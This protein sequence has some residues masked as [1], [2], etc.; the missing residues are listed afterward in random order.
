MYRNAADRPASP[1]GDGYTLGTA[2]ERLNALERRKVAAHDDYMSAMRAMQERQKVMGVQAQR[3][4]EYARGWVAALA[5]FS[6]Q[7]QASLARRIGS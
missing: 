6:L 3:G 4:D 2:V 5:E 7:I 1:A